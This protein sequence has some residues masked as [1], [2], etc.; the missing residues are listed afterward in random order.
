MKPLI[1]IVGVGNMGGAMAAHLLELGWPVQVRDIEKTRTAALAAQGAAVCTDAA[2]AARGCEVLIVCV[3]DAAQ[4]QL[5]KGNITA[6]ITK[7]QDFITQLNGYIG[8]GKLTAAQAQ[9]L[10]DAAN[11]IIAALN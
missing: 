10:I 5:G 1:G 7:L 4:T 11:A 6:V 9:P 3:V 8:S 2:E